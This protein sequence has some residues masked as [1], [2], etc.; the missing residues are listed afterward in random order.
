MY[1]T[2]NFRDV[3]NAINLDHE[4]SMP[5]PPPAM[6]P[7][8]SACNLNGRDTQQVSPGIVGQQHRLTRSLISVG[9]SVCRICHTNT[10]KEPLISPCRCKGTLAYV[11]LSCLERWLNQS[12]RTYCELCRYYFNAV[13]TPRYRW[14]ESLRIW[15]S[16]PR[17]RRNI[18]SDLLILTLL[19][20]VTVGLAAVCFLGMRY[21]IIEGNK[22]GISKPWTRGAIWFFLTIVI[23]GYVTTVYLLCRDQVSPW[24]RWWKSTVNV[25]LVV[26]PQL[27]R[28]R[29]SDESS[30]DRESHDGSRETTMSAV[31]TS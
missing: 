16:H 10:A 30:Q 29:S 9:S 5:M 25:R 13:E 3:G 11:H 20:I 12:C 22:I 2:G 26:D 19:T 17:N 4:H 8:G 31:D 15:I 24:Y 18:E 6:A 28:R 27:L 1:R 21:F 7:E 23:L 14:P